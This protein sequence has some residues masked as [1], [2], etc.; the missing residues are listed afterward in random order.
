[1]GVAA[2]EN[3]NTIAKCQGSGTAWGP[4]TN[5]NVNAICQRVGAVLGPKP[6][7]TPMPLPIFNV[8]VP[9]CNQK[10][11]KMPMPLPIFNVLVPFWGHKP[12]NAN[13]I[14]NSQCSAA[15]L[16]PKTNEN[17]NAM[18]T[19]QGSETKSQ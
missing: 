11:M 14:T 4:T 17:L 5:E 7:K 8:L 13:A 15:A 1:L 12:K 16:G 6:M 19:F 10:P 3:A 9:S 18:T 2:T